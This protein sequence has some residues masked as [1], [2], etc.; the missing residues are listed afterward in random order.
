MALHAALPHARR[1]ARA[2]VRRLGGGSQ[3]LLGEEASEAF[4]K[5]A[6]L[7]R[8][9]ILHFATHAVM[10]E[11]HPARSAIVL[12]PGA[13]GEDGRLQI[14]DVVGLDLKGRPMVLS[15]CR[16]AGGTL[17]EGEGVMGL[18][19]AFFQ[20]GVP[21]VVGS[22]W[23]LRDDDGER[24]FG[25]FYRHLGQGRSAAAAL[26][27]AQ[28]E[29]MA[30]GAPAAA[31]AGVVVLGYGDAVP[32]PDGA[33]GQRRSAPWVVLAAVAVLAGLVLLTRHRRAE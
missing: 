6:S 5:R 11:E 23:P 3:L 14:R 19:R 17:L 12:S 15:A 30:S 21:T 1:E 16:T 24:L 10:D 32:F 7:R 27:A 28:R 29:R 31:W 9:A 8:F 18:A 13:V 26:A 22:L 2:V 20:T 4:L 25:A 33:P